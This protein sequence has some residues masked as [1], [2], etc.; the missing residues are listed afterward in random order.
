MSDSD[1]WEVAPKGTKM[2]LEELE[3]KLEDAFLGGW[4]ARDSIEPL[5]SM[6][7][8]GDCGGHEWFDAW[9]GTKH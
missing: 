1:N 4:I 2:R 9:K 6:K 7:S 3:A 8:Y 5:K